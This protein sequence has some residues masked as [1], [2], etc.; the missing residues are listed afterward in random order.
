MAKTTTFCAGL[1]IVPEVPAARLPHSSDLIPSGFGLVRFHWICTLLPVVAELVET[2][3]CLRHILSNAAAAQ[4][5]VTDLFAS[6]LT[7]N[8]VVTMCNYIKPT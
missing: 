7:S 5:S 4:V 3:E 8:A 1:W 2:V 6:S